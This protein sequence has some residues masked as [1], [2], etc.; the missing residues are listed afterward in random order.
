[1][2]SDSNIRS[3]GIV[4]LFQFTLMTFFEVV[5]IIALAWLIGHVLSWSV[6]KFTRRA[7]VSQPQRVTISR[8]VRAVMILI[9]IVGILSVIGLESEAELLTIAGIGGLV[10]GI[11]FQG[12]FA[13]ILS[14]L[15]T[16]KEDTLRVGDVVEVGSERGKGHV[17]KVGLRNVWIKTENGALVVLGHATLDHGRY[18]NYTAAERLKKEFDT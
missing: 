6:V 7:G 1:M 4:Y 14:G 10:V 9:A 16:F 17:V 5:A 11:A 12:I 13:N 18:W 8:W 3:G 15:L 2:E